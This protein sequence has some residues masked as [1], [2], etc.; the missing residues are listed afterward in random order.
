M[1]RTRRFGLGRRTVLMKKLMI[2]IVALVLLFE[3]APPVD[4]R[5]GRGGGRG[6]GGR[7]GR[8]FGRG[9]RDGGGAPKSNAKVQELRDQALDRAA[10]LS[11]GRSV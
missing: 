3:F 7:V 8:G 6:R 9:G 2:L 11:L 10:R 1:A 5:G 4:A